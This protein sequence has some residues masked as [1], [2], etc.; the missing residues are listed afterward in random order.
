MC[1]VIKTVIKLY[2]RFDSLTFLLYLFIGD[3]ID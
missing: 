3:I 2:F 1:D